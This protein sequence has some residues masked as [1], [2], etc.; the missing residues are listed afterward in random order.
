MT[1]RAIEVDAIPYY[2]WAYRTPGAMR[3]WIPQGPDKP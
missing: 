1:A 3:A 2:A